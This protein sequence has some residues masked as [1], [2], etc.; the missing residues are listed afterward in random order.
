MTMKFKYKKPSQAKKISEIDPKYLPPR[1]SDDPHV[2][3]SEGPADINWMLNYALNMET[4]EKQQIIDKKNQ[5][6]EQRKMKELEQRQREQRERQE[7]Q[8]RWYVKNLPERQLQM[9]LT[10]R[11]DIWRCCG[12]R[13]LAEYYNH[14]MQCLS[15]RGVDIEPGLNLLKE[16][17]S[18]GKIL[19]LDEQT[20]NRLVEFA[21]PDETYTDLINRLLDFVTTEAQRS[22]TL[23]I[24]KLSTNN[25]DNISKN[26]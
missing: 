15:T 24:K 16:E 13:K 26:V 18:T 8:R 23:Q 7:E 20:H 14:S 12:H 17:Y 22:E 10:G 3:V 9:F 6:E 21:I 1:P 11:R 2:I 25:S 19:R 4:N 5:E